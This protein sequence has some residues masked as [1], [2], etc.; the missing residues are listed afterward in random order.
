MAFVI[1]KKKCFSQKLIEPGAKITD[2]ITKRA[3]QWHNLAFGVVWQCHDM[4]QWALR[5]ENPTPFRKVISKKYIYTRK[6]VNLK[7][8]QKRVWKRLFTSFVK[9]KKKFIL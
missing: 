2:E 3:V 8:G 1:G 7:F 4:P 9:S 5:E 6:L